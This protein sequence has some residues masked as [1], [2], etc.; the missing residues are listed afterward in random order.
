LPVLTLT[1]MPSIWLFSSLA[2]SSQRSARAGDVLNAVDLALQ[3]LGDILAAI[4]PRG[5][6]AERREQRQRRG[7]QGRSAKL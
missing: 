6:C 1:L 7:K 2:I 5:R 3:L 4:G